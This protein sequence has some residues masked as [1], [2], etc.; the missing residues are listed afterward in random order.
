MRFYFSLYLKYH[1]RI[2][3]ARDSTVPVLRK[4]WQATLRN[5]S[6]LQTMKGKSGTRTCTQSTYTQSQENGPYMHLHQEWRCVLS[7]SRIYSLMAGYVYVESPLTPL[8]LTRWISEYHYMQG[9]CFEGRV[10][11]SKTRKTV[12]QMCRMKIKGF[13]SRTRRISKPRNLKINTISKVLLFILLFKNDG[14][15]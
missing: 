3:L 9:S 5:L 1:Q 13:R 11:I 4:P 12:R 6:F 2:S 7:V 10:R 15:G 14:P 8:L